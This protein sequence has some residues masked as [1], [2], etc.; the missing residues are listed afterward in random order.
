MADRARAMARAYEALI[1][2]FVAW[3]AGEDAIRAAVVIGSRARTDHPADEWADLD[4]LIWSTDPAPYLNGTTWAAAI[5]DAWISFVDANAD[6][7]VQ[8]RRIL[9]AGGLDVDFA[10]VRPQGAG[11]PHEDLAEMVGVIFGRGVRVL[12]D[13]DGSVARLQA[14]MTPARPPPAPDAAALD[15]VAS[16]FW[17]HAVWTAKHLRR[18]ELWWAKGGCDGRL[19]DLLR[20]VLEWEAAARGRDRWFRGRFLEEWADPATV[21]G[22]GPAFARYDAKEVWAALTVTM[23]LFSGVARQL[24]ATL[25]LPYPAAAE[26]RARELVRAYEA[27]R[28]EEP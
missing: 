25:T 3:A 24:A 22:L 23:D 21:R 2:R 19:K 5:G 26:D 12:L 17:Y 4:I 1:E 13:K 8:E 20:I 27:T 15:R 16:D 28:G 9:F 11:L 10:F 18:G 14:A 6:P 7:R